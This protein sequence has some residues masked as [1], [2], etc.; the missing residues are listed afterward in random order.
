MSD[1][2]LVHKEGLRWMSGMI[3]LQC[4]SITQPWIGT[5]F[6][7]CHANHF[8]QIS[9][10]VRNLRNFLSQ[11]YMQ[12]TISLMSPCHVNT[13]FYMSGCMC[14]Y[15]VRGRAWVSGDAGMHN[16]FRF[17]SIQIQR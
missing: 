15:E 5:Y 6:V 16:V 7:M 9:D 11:M 2:G 14:S 10:H 8:P 1:R 12:L 4:S 13:Y 3:D 17:F